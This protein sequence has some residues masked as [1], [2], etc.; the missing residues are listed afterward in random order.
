MT[1]FTERV[2]NIIQSIPMG[3]VMTYGQI[4][5]LAGNKRGARQV[6]RILHSMSKKHQLPWHR[7]INA[8][9]EVAIKDDEGASV[10][11]ELLLQEGIQLTL[12]GKINLK[13]YRYYPSVDWI[14]EET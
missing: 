7:V 4:A 14:A 9:G 13:E 3:K 6:V 12:T 5:T 10:Q 1:L 8:K 11:K 2:L